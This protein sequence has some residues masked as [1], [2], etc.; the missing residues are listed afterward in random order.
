LRARGGFEVNLSWEDGH[1][2]NAAII[3]KLGGVLHVRLEQQTAVF[4]TKPGEML[5]LNGKL[6]KI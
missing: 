5:I 4:V 6:E 1:L 3:S 2:T